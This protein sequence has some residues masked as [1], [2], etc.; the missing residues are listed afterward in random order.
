MWDCRSDNNALVHL[1][2]IRL[3]G[4]V[5]LQ[6]HCMLWCLAQNP[7]DPEAQ[8]LR[9]LH[10]AMATANHAGMGP[11]ERQAYSHAVEMARILSVPEYGGTYEAWRRRPLPGILLRYCTD[12]A[13]FFA[14]RAFYRPTEEA[15]AEALRLAAQGRLDE[16]GDPG[17][18]GRR[19]R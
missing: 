18:E 12:A 6:L 16:S 13:R 14:L 8:E 1:H 19:R 10:W 4:V 11:E 3:A 7:A 2:G 5:D 9:S 17:W 15:H